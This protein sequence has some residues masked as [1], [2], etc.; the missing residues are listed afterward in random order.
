MTAGPRI[1]LAGRPEI[2]SDPEDKCLRIAIPLSDPADG[3]LVDAIAE[4]PTVMAYCRSVEADERAL[5]LVLKK[6]SATEGL[7]T[8]MTAV[9][10]LVDLTNDE[11]DEAAKTDEQRR[12]DELQAHRGEA[13]SELEAWWESRT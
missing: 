5:A 8:L 6:E 10:S 7:R 9:A 2:V 13:E 11:R 12:L 1:R 3:R 4:S